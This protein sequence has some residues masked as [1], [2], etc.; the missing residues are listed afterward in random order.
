MED[1]LTIEMLEEAV[2]MMS[3]PMKIEPIAL[4]IGLYEDMKG[5]FNLTDEQM[6]KKGYIKP[7]YIPFA[8]DYEY[9]PEWETFTGEVDGT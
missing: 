2:K 9:P 6:L 5:L 8:N 3:K 4:S 7:T 1:C